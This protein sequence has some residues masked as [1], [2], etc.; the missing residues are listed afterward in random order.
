MRRGLLSYRCAPHQKGSMFAEAVV[1][2][3]KGR[4]RGAGLKERSER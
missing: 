2:S 4:K 3:G 1:D